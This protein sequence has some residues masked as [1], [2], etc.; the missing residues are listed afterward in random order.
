[1]KLKSRRMMCSRGTNR[2]NVS[3]SESHISSSFFLKEKRSLDIIVWHPRGLYVGCG[4]GLTSQTVLLS[5]PSLPPP[6][7]TWPSSRGLCRPVRPAARRRH[8]PRQAPGL[9]PDRRPASPHHPPDACQP[10]HTPCHQVLPPL[11]GRTRVE[12]GGGH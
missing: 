8:S 10:R 6:R 3:F 9:G 2:L 11:Q 5:L 12:I 7:P 4:K 1:M